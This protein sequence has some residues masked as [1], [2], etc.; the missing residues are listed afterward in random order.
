MN[1]QTTKDMVIK[2][3]KKFLKDINEKDGFVWTRNFRTAMKMT[4]EDATVL[5][6]KYRER[7]L[8][9][10]YVTK[11][12]MSKFPFNAVIRVQYRGMILYIREITR[13]K[14]FFC[15]LAQNAYRYRDTD[16][17]HRTLKKYVR[18]MG[19]NGYLTEVVTI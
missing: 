12:V 2:K 8:A 19:E 1:E 15:H 4:Q 3:G 13:D 18:I 14:I 7:E 11:D 16:S 5:L 10:A 17:A 6:K 9:D